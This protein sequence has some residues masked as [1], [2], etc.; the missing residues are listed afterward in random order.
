MPPA[1]KGDTVGTY[2]QIDA[3]SVQGF[4][5]Q[6]RAFHEETAHQLQALVQMLNEMNSSG[7]WRDENYDRYYAEF[8][9]AARQIMAALGEFRDNQ[10]N[11]LHRLVG[12]TIDLSYG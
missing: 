7:E 1:L 3:E 6:L 9:P 10:E 2:R 11:A 8:E 5:H 4:A 12:D